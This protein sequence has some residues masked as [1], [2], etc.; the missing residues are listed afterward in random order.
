[1]R[2]IVALLMLV[3]RDNAMNSPS[4][5]VKIP[6]HK[7]LSSQIPHQTQKIPD[8]SNPASFEKFLL[9]DFLRQ[10]IAWSQPLNA[11]VGAGLAPPVQ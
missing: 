8:T 11:F 9:R 2:Q 6:S 4:L 5:N 10:E 3:S 7:K 1:M